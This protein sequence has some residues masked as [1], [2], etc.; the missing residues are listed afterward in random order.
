MRSR[1]IPS[2]GLA[3]LAV[4]LAALAVVV[5]AGA[6]TT[7]VQTIVTGP[8]LSSTSTTTTSS[9]TTTTMPV[10]TTTPSSDSGVGQSVMPPTSAR[11]STA[12]RS[13]STTTTAPPP[14]TTTTTSQPTR[15]DDVASQSGTFEGGETTAVVRLGTVRTVTVSVPR[16]MRVT[17]SVSCG[18]L[19][20]SA[21]GVT[22]AAL[23]I[24]EP[25][26]T[27][28]VTI[29]VPASAPEPATWHLDTQ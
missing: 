12:P 13:S 18:I 29:R 15:V 8:P 25:A 26:S 9:T 5:V 3:A 19:N 27:C 16:G 7:F 17:L 28:I 11:P 20:K 10:S 21:T 4:L 22:S 1:Q 2:G 14:P 6:R 24:S 23:R